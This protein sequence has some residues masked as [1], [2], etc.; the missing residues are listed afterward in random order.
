MSARESVCP[1]SSKFSRDERSLR[2]VDLRSHWT[3]LG[4]PVRYANRDQVDLFS[5]YI[6]MRDRQKRVDY[7]D[8]W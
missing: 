7:L 2:Y 8:F 4:C 5:F 6:Y 3:C 1:T